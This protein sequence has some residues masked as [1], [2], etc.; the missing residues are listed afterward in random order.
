MQ[1]HRRARRC[2]RRPVFVVVALVH[3]A[4]QSRAEGPPAPDIAEVRRGL[5]ARDAAFQNLSFVGTYHDRYRM[6]RHGPF[7]EKDRVIKVLLDTSPGVTPGARAPQ[8]RAKV[9]VTETADLDVIPLLPQGQT[10]V[11]WAAMFDPGS[12][13]PSRKLEAG[14]QKSPGGTKR[15]IPLGHISKYSLIYWMCPPEDLLGL[16]GGSPTDILSGPLVTPTVEGVE[17]IDGHP[18]V[19]IAWAFDTSRVPPSQV[20]RGH[21]WLAPKLGYAMVRREDSRRPKPDDPWKPVQR[22]DCKDFLRSN[23]LWV[24]RRVAFLRHTYHDDGGYELERELDA[25]FDAWVVNQPLRDDMFRLD[26]PDGTTVLDQIRGITYIQGRISNASL[27]RQAAAAKKL[28][29]GKDPARRKIQLHPDE[30]Q[31]QIPSAAE[32]HS[33]VEFPSFVTLGLAG[34]LVLGVSFALIHHRRTRREKVA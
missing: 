7:A 12:S 15:E 10:Q 31:P 28:A 26:F 32:S 29:A 11:H 5:A 17:V 24:P 18:T 13:T 14:I 25:T 30:R 21:F 4:A 20:F 33:I 23:G 27:D 1:G 34:A 22:I 2:G 8:L 16:C 6:L 3:L 9:D 19:K